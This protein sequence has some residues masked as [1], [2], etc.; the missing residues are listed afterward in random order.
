MHVENLNASQENAAR[1]RQR[2]LD[3]TAQIVRQAEKRVRDDRV[4]YERMQKFKVVRA[5]RALCSSVSI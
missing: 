4:E 2:M 3:A 1:I 5:W